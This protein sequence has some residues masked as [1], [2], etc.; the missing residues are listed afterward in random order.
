M[1]P[2]KSVAFHTLGCKLNFAESSTLARQFKEAGWVKH[3]FPAPSDVYLINTCSVTENADRECRSVVNRALKSNPA[4]RI[5]VVG[6][7]AQLKPDAI[8][9][10]PGVSL[11]LGASEKFNVLQHLNHLDERTEASVM[12]CEIGEV[13]SFISSWS[14]NDRTRTFLKVQDGC[15]YNC[16]FCTIPLAR[17]RSRSDTIAGVISRVHDL[18]ADGVSEIVLTGVNLGD[19]G[20]RDASGRHQDRFIDLARAIDQVEGLK[21]VRISSIEPNLVTQELIEGIAASD[22]FMPHF[23]MPLQSGS[24]EILGLMRRRYRSALYRERVEYIRSL[25]PHASIGV[26]V[27]TGFPGESNR[28][29]EETHQFLHDLPV[30]YLHVF[31]Y[32][33]RDNTPAAQMKDE[34]PVS[35]RRERNQILRNLSVKK[36][37]AFSVQ[38]IGTTRPVLFEKEEAKGEMFGYTDNYIR[39][40]AAYDPS[41]VNRIVPCALGGFGN[42]GIIH[43]APLVHNHKLLHDV[44]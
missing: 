7:Y 39:V 17:G 14:S 36:L 31:T 41:L 18:I 13:C 28:H 24:D 6:C 44:A 32:S 40:S 2:V 29:F 33:E 30:S 15:D 38:Y 4:A 11:V 37:H 3:D 26:D 27:I 1:R 19:F 42:G 34:V 8:A 43:A 9:A 25:M 16:T 20:I 35:L 12:A 5:I 21:R 23:H 10:I 22:K